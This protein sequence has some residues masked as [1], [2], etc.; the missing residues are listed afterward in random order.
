MKKFERIQLILSGVCLLLLGLAI[1]FAVGL[2]QEKGRTS[3]LEKDIA[4]TENQIDNIEG[5]CVL[6]EK[7]LQLEECQNKLQTES[8]FPADVIDNKEVTNAVI[9]VVSD[10]RL[11]MDRLDYRGTSSY[12]IGDTQYTK[13]TY[14]LQCSSQIGKESR[15]LTLLELF[16]EMREEKYPTLL[17]DNINLPDGDPRITLDIIIITQ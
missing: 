3:K 8:P 13:A 9:A 15:F 5:T 11:N 12:Q 10:A 1:F 6:I 14:A 17:V 16:E 2:L 7:Q 4:T